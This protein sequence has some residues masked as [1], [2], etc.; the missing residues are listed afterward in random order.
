MSNY[1]PPPPGSTGPTRPMNPQPTNQPPYQQPPYQQ[2]PYQPGQPQYQQ[3]PPPKKGKAL[4]W[5][6][7]GCGGFLLIG[8]IAVVAIGWYG[9]GRMKQAGFDPELMQRNPPLAAAKL[10][11]GLDN[12]KEL[13]S[14]DEKNNTLTVK[15]KRTGK[16]ITL[17]FDQDKNGNITFKETSADG[18]ETSMSIKGDGDKGSV[19]INTPEGTTKIGGNSS[20]K[21]P[22]WLPQYPDVEI[23][24]TYE[25]ENNESSS[26]GF[27]FTTDDSI[28]EVIDF[29]EDELKSAGFKIT[30]QAKGQ[31]SGSVVAND[32]GNKRHVVIGASI[33]SGKTKVSINSQTNK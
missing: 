33:E 9:Y 32:A 4:M 15:D 6:L 26:V 17:T 29:Y 21:L 5:T 8:V 16:T 20:S 28:E 12:E 24:G 27:T 14:I 1:P 31:N 23:E 19:E 30:T 2:Q 10:A 11:I 7:I 22:D 13:I 18:K 3:A 25:V